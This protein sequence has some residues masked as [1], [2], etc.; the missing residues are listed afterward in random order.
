MSGQ[1]RVRSV[2][3]A[4][5]ILDVLAHS[6]GGETVTAIA[7]AVG[8]SKSAVFT[9]LQTLCSRGLVRSTGVGVDRRYALGLRLTYL[10]EQAL[11][12]VSIREVAMPFLRRLTVATGLTS[13]VATRAENYAI[14][15]G[16]VD[17]IEGVRFDL[18]MGQRE[19]LH[20]T[21]VGKAILSAL[22][23]QEV[24]R[25]MAAVPMIRRTSRT[26]RDLDTLV[27]EVEL[28]R[29]R[30]WAIDD[31]EDAEGVVCIGAVVR[32]HSGR[33]AG[34]ISV[35][36]LKSGLSPSD[37]ERLGTLVAECAAE[38]SFAMGH[39]GARFGPRE[40]SLPGPAP[41]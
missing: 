33:P 9:T 38:V 11:A 32:D 5:D 18:H 2:D 29:R 20:S 22:T 13:R 3:R 25:T 16:R 34:G 30:G 15:V 6:M 27:A 31:E 24:R 35:T 1:E 8:G 4:V 17:N 26:I 41:A 10:G 19:Y 12:R 36:R 7:A 14:A 40:R 28:T 37:S 39:L 23:D 21:S